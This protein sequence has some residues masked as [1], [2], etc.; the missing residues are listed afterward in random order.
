MDEAA[1][2]H[3]RISG[4]KP[5]GLVGHRHIIER[6]VGDNQARRHHGFIFQGP[7]GIG[8][9]STAYQLA[10]HLFA[11]HSEAG[12]F[13]ESTSELT[14]DDPEVSLLRAGSHPDAMAIEE[15]PEKPS[16]GISID[17]IRA[18]I[19]FLSHTPSRGGMRFVLIDAMDEMNVNG[20]NALLKT[21]EEPPENTILVIISHGMTPILPTIRSRTQ[22]I[23]FAPLGYEE[24][25]LVIKAMFPEAE[26]NWIDVAATLSEGAPG[27][28]AMLAEAGAPDLY[29]ET[30][31]AFAE[32]QLS[33]LQLDALS[34]QWGA[35]GIKNAARRQLARQLF[36]RLLVKATRRTVGLS[37]EAGQPKLDIEEQAIDRLADRTS[38]GNLTEIREILL[39]DLYEAERLNLDAAPILFAALSRMNE[40]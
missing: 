4:S 33:G 10:E 15:D 32:D 18:V 24:T 7:K 11:A 22:V 29:A 6:L 25:C 36:D 26:Q 40:G 19:P 1:P 8:K 12:L 23:K 31:R 2:D 28:A 14:S 27:K 13:E 5:H 20:A 3:P 9:A 34:A 37:P 30:C 35:G 38:V 16:G 17:Q 21:L 39:S